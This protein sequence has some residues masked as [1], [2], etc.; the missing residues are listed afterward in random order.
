M[1]EYQAKALE[2]LETYPESEYKNSL[3]TMINYVVDRKK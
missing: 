3:R 2:L 1:K